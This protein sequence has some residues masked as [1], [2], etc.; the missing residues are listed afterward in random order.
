MLEVLALI[1]FVQQP[2]M[3]M[4]DGVASFYSVRENG[5]LTA[6]GI[7]LTD[8]GFTCAMLHGEFGAKV[9]VVAENGK[10]VVC[11]IT[12]R[13]PH[14]RGRVVDLSKTAMRALH[15]RAGTLKVKVYRVSDDT[16]EGPFG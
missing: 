1:M 13:G 7:P 6:S 5:T 11:R 15:P 4:A 10:S 12:D 14:V 16:P 8:E 2:I 9:L 3:P